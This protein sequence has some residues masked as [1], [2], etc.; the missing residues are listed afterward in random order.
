MPNP[1][2]TARASDLP[3]GWS[4]PKPEELA[5]PTWW[6]AFLALG[7]TFIVW[8]LFASFIILTIGLITFAVSLTGW[9]GDIRHEQR[10]Q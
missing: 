9:I 5:E 2:D 10:E 6:P 1:Q 7:A 8:G 4:R 3:P